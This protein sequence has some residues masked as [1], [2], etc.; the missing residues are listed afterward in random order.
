MCAGYGGFQLG[1]GTD[2]ESFRHTWRKW[3]ATV[4]GLRNNAAAVSLVVL[5][6]ASIWGRAELP[7]QSTPAQIALGLALHMLARRV[8]FSCRR[9]SPRLRRLVAQIR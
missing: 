5:P 6:P 1:A 8:E 7:E 3:A 2:A 4:L 9:L